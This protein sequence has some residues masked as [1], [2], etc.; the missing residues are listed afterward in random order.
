MKAEDQARLEL[1]RNP[2][3]ASFDLCTCATGCKVHMV[4][5]D[6]QSKGIKDGHRNGASSCFT[7]CMLPCFVVAALH[8]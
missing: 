7:A 1:P 6:E 3:C 4:R 2:G 8:P 5:G